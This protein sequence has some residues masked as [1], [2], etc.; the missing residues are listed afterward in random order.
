M[1]KHVFLFD[2]SSRAS[3]YGIGTYIQQMIV[4]LSKMSELLLSV[5]RVSSNVEFFSKKEMQ[6][7]IEYHI[8]E[9]CFSTEGKSCQHKRNICYLMRLN[10]NCEKDGK[11]IFL[12][13]H[14]SHLDLIPYV[15]LWLPN[16]RFYLTI[17]FQRWCYSLNGNLFDFKRIIHSE[18]E[19]LS[20][21]E[22]GIHDSYVREKN[23]DQ[24]VDI[25]RGLCKFTYS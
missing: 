4:C 22:Q 15:R 10:C 9:P 16:S 2:E 24:R 17:H 7:Y 18:R 21:I 12:F 14:M 11:Y 23:Y 1:K 3:T 20:L 6:G 25:G 8:P 5:V 13:S 19:N